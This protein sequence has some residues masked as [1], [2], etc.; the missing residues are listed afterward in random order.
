MTGGSLLLLMLLV[1]WTSLLL[2][3]AAAVHL[4]RQHASYRAEQLAGRGYIRTAG[5]RVLAAMIYVTVALLQVTG[6]HIPGSGGLSPEALVVFCAV[7]LIWI[8]NSAL[9]IAVRRK[10]AAHDRDQPRKGPE[11]L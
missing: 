11:D 10:L 8:T 1:S 9:D 6:V 7:Q 3:A 2:Q 5:C 4:R